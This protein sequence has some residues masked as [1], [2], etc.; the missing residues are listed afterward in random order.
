MIIN[1][2]KIDSTCIKNSDKNIE[3]G[4]KQFDTQLKSVISLFMVLEFPKVLHQ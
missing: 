4:E 1:E 3:L 2:T